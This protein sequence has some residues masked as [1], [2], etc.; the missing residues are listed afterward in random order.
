MPYA[1]GARAR[2]LDTAAF[3]FDLPDELIAQEPPPERGTS[4]LLVLHRKT[5][6][7]E[8]TSFAQLAEYLRPGDL[9]V[10]NNTKVFPARLLGRRLPGGGAVECLLMCQI[11]DP[12]SQIPTSTGPRGLGF[13]HLGSGISAW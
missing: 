13:G 4:R 10:L 7:I 1:F 5:G 2:P 12:E 6:D 11:P 8:H 9:L 3:N